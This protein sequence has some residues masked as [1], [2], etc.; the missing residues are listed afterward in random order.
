MGTFWKWFF[1]FFY[2]MAPL[3]L[4]GDFTVLEN[5]VGIVADNLAVPAA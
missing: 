3:E 1:D 5:P 2:P 4:P